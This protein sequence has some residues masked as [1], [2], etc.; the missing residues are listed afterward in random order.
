MTRSDGT[1][2]RRTEERNRAKDLEFLAQL[3]ELRRE[4]NSEAA[5]AFVKRNTVPSAKEWKRIAALRLLEEIGR[6]ED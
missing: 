6:W 3:A 2:S 4:R 1:A 5:R